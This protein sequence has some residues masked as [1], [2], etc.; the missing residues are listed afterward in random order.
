MSSTLCGLSLTL[1][2]CAILSRSLDNS[3]FLAVSNSSL[4][5]AV[6][7]LAS[8]NCS[9]VNEI[10]VSFSV[11]SF[12]IFSFSKLLLSKRLSRLERLV[13]ASISSS[14][15]MIFSSSMAAIF[16]FIDKISLSVGDIGLVESSLLPLSILLMALSRSN[17][18]TCDALRAKLILSTFVSAVEN[19]LIDLSFSSF[20][21][22]E[23]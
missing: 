5:F 4:R 20:S 22:F 7:T 19:F 23:I 12:S 16:C 15:S 14:E 8:F 10:R 21:L 3:S 1:P 11:S 17:F 18:S 9:S 6:F 2:C 13:R